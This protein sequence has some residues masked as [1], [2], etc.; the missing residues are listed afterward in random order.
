[1][2]KIKVKIA[3]KKRINTGDHGIHMLDLDHGWLETHPVISSKLLTK[4]V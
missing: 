2:E 4:G 3:G 1:V